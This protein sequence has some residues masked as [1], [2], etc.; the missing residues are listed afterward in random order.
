VEP[1][2]DLPQP[3]TQLRTVSAAGALCS[4]AYLV[5]AW[6]THNL[7]KI[8]LTLFFCVFGL[9]AAA[10]LWT[11][12]KLSQA[13]D[14]AATVRWIVAWAL[15]FRIIGF[16]GL[17]IYE[18]DF[19]RY[20]WDGRTVALGGNPY[21]HPPADA[22][23]DDSVPPKFQDILDHI[24][25]PRVPTVYGP[26]CQAVFSLAYWI[27]PGE[28]WPLKL[29]FLCADLL[30]LYLLFL[31]LRRK[32]YLVIYAWS[33]LLIKEISFSAHSDILAV[34]LMIAAIA[35]FTKRKPALASMLLAL[36]AGSKVIA[37][38]FVPFLLPRKAG[39]DLI[40][41]WLIFAGTLLLAYAP[42]AVRGGIESQG[43]GVFLQQW[44]FNSSAFAILQWALGDKA[45]RLVSLSLFTLAFV[46][47]IAKHWGHGPEEIPPG[48]VLLA[49]FL[50]F[51]PVA[52]PW[53]FVALIPFVA[54]R[55]SAWGL[56]LLTT[57]FLSYL[58][59]L[60]LDSKTLPS[61][62]HPVW[63]RPLEILPVIAALVWGY[64]K[65]LTKNSGAVA[66]PSTY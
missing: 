15:L 42:F 63:V 58:T 21:L 35:A 12:W 29:I 50:L 34:C 46:W 49:L 41:A 25:Y 44:E 33:P 64:R 30:T 17:P 10:T 6:A 54:L 61:F 8:P 31:L 18:D 24:N 3:T 11:F 28:L 4:V 62:N 38:L 26:V 53:Y 51:S 23:G 52:N 14:S 55:P 1:A 47:L 20:L 56:T 37:L 32:S 59:G 2:A 60:N 7:P 27:D 19:Y 39:K 57:V 48:D 9:A 36:A 13:P 65:G 40:R 45:G 43:M 22:F 5:L 66:A 16:W